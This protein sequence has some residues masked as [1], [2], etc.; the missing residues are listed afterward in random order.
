M[1]HYLSEAQI[2]YKTRPF[3]H[4][5]RFWGAAT[6]ACFVAPY[7]LRKVWPLEVRDVVVFGAYLA[8]AACIGI[9]TVITRRMLRPSRRYLE[10]TLI[11]IDTHGIWKETGR[12]RSLMLGAREI[13]SADVHRTRLNAVHRVV[14]RGAKREASIEGLGDMQSLLSDVLGTFRP[15]KVNEY[16]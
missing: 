16:R 8:L 15:A 7:T 3:S 14:L 4:T 6:I 11:E 10:G 5:G 9:L 1:K 2:A 13:Q 12:S